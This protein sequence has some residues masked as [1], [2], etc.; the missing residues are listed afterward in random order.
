MSGLR[1]SNS[2]INTVVDTLRIRGI[3]EPGLLITSS[4]GLV[5]VG[6]SPTLT[7]LTVTGASI[8]GSAVVLGPLTANSVNALVSLTTPN[9]SI[10]NLDVS[11]AT[12]D[13]LTSTLIE[14]ETVNVSNATITNG[15]VGFLDVSNA[16]VD[17]LDVSAASINS[18]DASNAT[19]TVLDVSSASIHLMDVS[20]ADITYLD[21]S[22]AT[23]NR[24][25]ASNATITILDVSAASISSLDASNAT[26]TYLDVSAASISLLDSSNA[27][28]TILDV[29]AATFNHL[30]ASSASVSGRL[31]AG[32]AYIGDKFQPDPSQNFVFINATAG[33]TVANVRGSNL[34]TGSLQLGANSTHGD[35]ILLNA[36]GSTDINS[37]D[38]SA[39]VITSHGDPITVPS[40][41]ITM[42][43][44]TNGTIPAGWLLCDGS[45]VLR[46]QYSKLYVLIGTIYGSGDGTTT[47]NLPNMQMRF[48]LGAG[49]A[50]SPGSV[51]GNSDI[52]L[53]TTNL[54]AH[55]HGLNNV[56]TLGFANHDH[57]YD[58]LVPTTANPVYE[59]NSGITVDN[60]SFTTLTPRPVTTAPRNNNELHLTDLAGQLPLT[61]S[62]GSGSTFSILPPFLALNFIIKY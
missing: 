42:Y 39:G 58:V 56:Q 49:G 52:S 8:L 57:T 1:S 31:N 22:A 14:A 2:V 30:D 59:W 11:N 43:G 45:A 48:P 15:F 21:V 50:Y 44:G 17:I 62:I 28:I 23:F 12:I 6:T 24:L 34:S 27:T 9:G 26:I 20:N 37:L 33:Q 38:V 55:Q 10:T 16:I 19:I 40:G 5:S 51:G 3:T 7:N 35:N 29:S 46:S 53:N 18:L 61:D 25:D 60:V 54:P 36:N 13:T 47:F 4:S 41:S 32:Y